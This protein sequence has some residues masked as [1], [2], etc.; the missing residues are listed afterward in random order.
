MTESLTVRRHNAM[1]TLPVG[2]GKGLAFTPTVQTTSA[3]PL[4]RKRSIRR[5]RRNVQSNA[6]F[7]LME[8]SVNVLDKVD[9][10]RSTL[11]EE[12]GGL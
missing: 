7:P 3:A 5:R 10:L 9:M 4:T 12:V 6:F 8:V 1:Q 2:L 11:E